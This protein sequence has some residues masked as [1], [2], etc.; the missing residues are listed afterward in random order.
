MFRDGRLVLLPQKYDLP[1]EWFRDRCQELQ[2]FALLADE[3]E[4]H[5]V[6]SQNQVAPSRGACMCYDTHDL[7]FEGGWR[8]ADEP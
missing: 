2:S 6:I 3:V 4:L 7:E 5:R 8:D 1:L